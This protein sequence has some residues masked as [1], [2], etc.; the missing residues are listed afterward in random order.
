MQVI[1]IDGKII[2][3][4]WLAEALNI[5]S[6]QSSNEGRLP[7][8]ITQIGEQQIA[9]IVDQLQVGRDVVVK[10]LGAHLHHIYGLIGSTL[11][12]DGSIVLILNSNELIHDKGSSLSAQN[13][14]RLPQM[15]RTSKAFEILIVDDSFSVRRVVANLVKKAGWEPILAKNG[16]EA[17]E[18]IQRAVRLP[19]LI[20]LDVEMPQMDGYE[21]TS[22]LRANS[23][24]QNLPIVMLT[25][26]AGEKHRQKAFEVGATEY[27]IKPYRD[28][29]LLS[30]INYLISQSREIILT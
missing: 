10:T 15:T 18:I 28:S 7:V 8:I 12:G 25:S 24:Y 9:L 30:L 26:R 21:L 14:N 6:G 3:V 13:V 4:V 29:V 27:M 2:Q 19:D 22:T 11:M 17:L 5:T 23:D 1:S 20:L 16:L